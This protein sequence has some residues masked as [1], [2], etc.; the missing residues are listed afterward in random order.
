ME[1]IAPVER[2]LKVGDKV[3]ITGMDGQSR[4]ISVTSS[5]V[6]VDP[7]SQTIIYRADLEELSEAFPPGLTVSVEF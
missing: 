5:S 2:M 3:Q 4:Q 6:I 7:A 1:F